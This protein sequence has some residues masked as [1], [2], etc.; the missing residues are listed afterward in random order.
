MVTVGV[1][2]LVLYLLLRA[3]AK[4]T[5][6]S[7]YEPTEVVTY[8]IAYGDIVPYEETGRGPGQI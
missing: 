8:T 2:G 4:A 5:Y 7:P 3:K 6:F 1:V